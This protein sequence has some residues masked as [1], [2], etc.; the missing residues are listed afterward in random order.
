MGQSVQLP[1]DFESDL[2]LQA[3][4]WHSDTQNWDACLPTFARGDFTMDWTLG[5]NQSILV[6][7]F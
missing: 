4:L 1:M 7:C 5:P 3:N 2:S 6:C